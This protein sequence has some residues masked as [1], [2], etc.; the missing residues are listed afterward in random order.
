V[1]ETSVGRPK[2]KKRLG[3]DNIKIGFKLGVTVWIQIIW[4]RTGNS[5][6]IFGLHKSMQ[7]LD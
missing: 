5:V 1:H 4:Y 3:V 2:T 7:Y 6:G